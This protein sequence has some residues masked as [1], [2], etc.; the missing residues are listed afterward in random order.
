[1]TIRETLEAQ[2]DFFKS[3]ITRDFGF[4]YAALGVL[5]EGISQREQEILSALSKDLGKS[6]MEGYMMEVGMVLEELRFAMR[7]LYGWTRK[8][9]VK[10]PIHSFPGRSYTMREP[11]GV[12]LIMAPWNYPFQLAMIPLIGAIAAGNC[13]IVKPSNYAPN[14]SAIIAEILTEAFEPRFVDTVLGGREQNTDLLAQRF[15]MI[16]FTGGVTVGKLVAQAAARDLTPVVLELGGKSPCIVT[17]SANIK[18]A[19]RRIAFGKFI[20]SGQTCVAPDYVLVHESA[21]QALMDALKQEIEAF[22]GSEPLKSPSYPHMI[23]EK[24]FDRV[25]GLLEGETVLEGGV[26]NR[27]TLH[28]APTLLRVIDPEAPVMKEEIFGPVL[29]ILSYRT[30]REAMDF[31]RN[32]EK[33]LALYLFTSDKKEKKDVLKGISFGGGCINDTVMHL[34]NPKLPFGGVGQS[35][36]GSYHGKRSF[37]VFGHEKSI[38]E[39]GTWFD[40]KLRYPPYTDQKLSGIKKIMK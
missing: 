10:T 34:A 14:T 4:R 9:R 19:A 23:S 38:L 40:A 5:K 15:D 36:M 16:F 35:G 1:M 29:P 30:L 26:C 24:Q 28:I 3:G 21:E 31:V 27:E 6:R 32:R 13:I 33:P 17:Q 39:R 18:T 12:A 8:K 11:Y 7:H 20:N 2:Q 37:E 25:M 22:Y